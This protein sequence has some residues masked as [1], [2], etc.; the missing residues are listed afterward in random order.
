MLPIKTLQNLFNL[1]APTIALGL[2]LLLKEPLPPL[3]PKAAVPTLGTY[4]GV[5]N[6]VSS[7]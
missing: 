7:H 1:S 5:K 6:L 4:L 2:Y 3:S